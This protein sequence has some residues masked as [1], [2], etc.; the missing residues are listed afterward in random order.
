MKNKEVVEKVNSYYK[1]HPEVRERTMTK[2]FEGHRRI[3]KNKPTKLEKKLFGI[4]DN[5]NVPYEPFYLIKPKFIVDVKIDNLIIQADG[6]YW[7]GHPRL[8]PFTERQMAQQKRDK[9]QDIYLH[10]CGYTVIRIW[11]SE[12]TFEKIVSVLKQHGLKI[13]K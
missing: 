10:K 11:E 8:E 1:N 7:H 12:L 6:D 4:L 13:P 2:M 3:Q 9:A 5:L